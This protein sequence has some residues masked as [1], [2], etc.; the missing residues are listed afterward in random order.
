MGG[1][2]TLVGDLGEGA[3]FSLSVPVDGQ[4]LKNTP[5]RA[6]GLTTIVFEVDHEPMMGEAVH[7][8]GEALA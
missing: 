5:G 4:A 6:N 1:D 7:R 8:L 3:T 2:I